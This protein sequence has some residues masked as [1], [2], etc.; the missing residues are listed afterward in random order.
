MSCFE[1]STFVRNP[2]VLQPD[3]LIQACHQLGWRTEFIAQVLRVYP[4]PQT[5]FG[6]EFAMEVQGSQVTYN[7]YFLRD[8]RQLVRELEATFDALYVDY[9]VATVR[10]EFEA[11]G[12]KYA[13]DTV[14]ANEADQFARR[15]TMVGHTRL[16]EETEKRTEI[17]FA[18][19]KDGTVVSDS[20]YIPKDLHEKADQAMAAIDHRFGS[21]RKEGEH[22]QRKEIPLKYKG[23]TYCNVQNKIKAK[24]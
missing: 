10:K 15:F 4:P 11:L 9:A 6:G 1:S 24:H 7:S 3:L 19:R 17:R 22:I 8:G 21:E 20:D 2:L 16:S 14:K 13:P 18:V 23:K 5:R 12:F